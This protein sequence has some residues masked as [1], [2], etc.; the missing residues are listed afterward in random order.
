MHAAI[1][2]KCQG[3]EL[4]PFAQKPYLKAPVSTHVGMYLPSFLV[5]V[6]S[7]CSVFV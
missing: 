5:V 7:A 3:P 1:P 4:K 6:N 2:H